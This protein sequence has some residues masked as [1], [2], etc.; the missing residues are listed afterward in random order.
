[1]L[2][3]TGL[4]PFAMATGSRGLHVVAPVRR[5]LDYPELF[6]F[7]KAL[8]IAIADER[9]DILTT[10]FHKAERDDRVFVDVLRNRWAQTAVAPYS[11]RARPGAPVA[12]PLR[13]DEVQT[14]GP[15]PFSVRTMPERLQAE[16]DPWADI[17]G[18]AA[19]P[20]A[21]AKRLERRGR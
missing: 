17:A 19:S 9:P 10:E 20:R 3:E 1:L 11:V 18:A 7:A 4:E 21:A 12:T 14:A 13:W 6:A 5:E 2:R 8:A 15:H 16:G